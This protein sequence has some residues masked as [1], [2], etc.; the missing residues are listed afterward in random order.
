MK[1]Q[2][3]DYELEAQNFIAEI[4]DLPT[5]LRPQGQLAHLERII[6]EAS[7]GLKVGKPLD[8]TY[9]DGE[10]KGYRQIGT[11]TVNEQVIFFLICCQKALTQE[12]EQP[13]NRQ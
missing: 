8:F 2:G 7:G 3:Y 6:A 13:H 9:E 11:V 1:E 10:W 12:M 4:K 5:S